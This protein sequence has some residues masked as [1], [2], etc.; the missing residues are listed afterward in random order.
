[1]TRSR[2]PAAKTAFRQKEPDKRTLTSDRIADDIEA[3]QSSGGRIEVLG[4]TRTLKKLD[5]SVEAPAAQPAQPRS[6]TRRS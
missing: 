4:I 5:D 2:T 6:G 3:F 1:M